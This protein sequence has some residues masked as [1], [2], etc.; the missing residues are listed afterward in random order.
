MSQILSPPNARQ[1]CGRD[2]LAAML[3]AKRSTGVAPEM[4]LRATM[5]GAKRSA[6][7]APEM[8]LREC[9]THMPLPSQIRLPTLAVKPDIT[10]SPKEGYQWPHKKDSCPPIFFKDHWILISKL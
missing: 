7:V 3:A 8:N 4:N 6:G 5:L 2:G 1:V 9:V 10:R